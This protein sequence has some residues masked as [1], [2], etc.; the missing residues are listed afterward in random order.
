DLGEAP[1]LANCRVSPSSADLGEDVTVS[2]TVTGSEPFEVSVDFG[3]GTVVEGLPATHAYDE[4]GT[5][6]VTITATNACGSDTCTVTVHVA[7]ECDE[8]TELNTVFFDFERSSLSEE[9]RSRLD[10]NIDVLR[11][12]PD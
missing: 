1:A 10:E 12:C 9:A 8:V 3:D 4:G 2:A 5:Y 6:T 7:D 11:R